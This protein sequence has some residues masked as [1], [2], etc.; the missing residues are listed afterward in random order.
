MSMNSKK[1]TASSANVA[2]RP[3]SLGATL[4]RSP[5]HQ[6]IADYA[7]RLWLRKGRP[8]GRDLEIWLEAEK[9]LKSASRSGN[10]GNSASDDLGKMLGDGEMTDSMEVRVEELGG[11]SPDR[12]T[13]SL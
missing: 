2:S 4:G 8:D 5:T 11:R 3:E 6:E 10:L 7:H 9:K 12:S 13:T 1:R